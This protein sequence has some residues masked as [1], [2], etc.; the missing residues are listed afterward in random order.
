MKWD[1]FVRHYGD[2]DQQQLDPKYFQEFEG[3]GVYYAATEIEARL[4]AGSPVVV[5]GGGNS[6]GQAAVF[7]AGAGCPVTVVIRGLVVQE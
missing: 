6:A 4:C 3:N 1:F 7:L 2:N 5:A